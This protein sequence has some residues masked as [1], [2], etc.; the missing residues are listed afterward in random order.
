MTSN[1]ESSYEPDSGSSSSPYAD[2]VD[3]VSQADDLLLAA[4]IAMTR[5]L[6]EAG[7]SALSVA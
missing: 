1:G 5:A 3:R 2:I 7:R 6:A 4:N